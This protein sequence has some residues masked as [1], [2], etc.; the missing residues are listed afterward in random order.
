MFGCVDQAIDTNHDG[1]IS[2]D[3]EFNAIDSNK[4]GMIDKKEYKKSSRVR[5]LARS[6]SV[7]A[8]KEA[9][10]KDLQFYQVRAN[11]GCSLF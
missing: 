6:K 8:L 11:V 1:K 7:K 3:E 10:A 9:A 5:M 2:V 4:D